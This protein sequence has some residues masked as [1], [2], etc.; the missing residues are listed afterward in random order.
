MYP[1]VWFCYEAAQ[2]MIVALPGDVS[3]W[4]SDSTVPESMNNNK[5][6]MELS[7]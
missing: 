6:Y 4:M 2:I 7:E 1:L 5:I 3:I